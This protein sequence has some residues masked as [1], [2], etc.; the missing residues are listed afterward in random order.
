M[1][2]NVC[3][4]VYRVCNGESQACTVGYHLYTS[5]YHD[6]VGVDPMFNTVFFMFSGV[7]LCVY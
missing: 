3:T 1:Y 7:Y 6:I 4:E 2:S 5:E